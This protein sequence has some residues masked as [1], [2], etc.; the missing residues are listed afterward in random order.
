MCTADGR[1][2]N[3]CAK[4]WCA[5]NPG[6]SSA[7]F[8]LYWDSLDGNAKAVSPSYFLLRW[9][10]ALT[11]LLGVRGTSS[12]SGGYTLLYRD[13][14]ISLNFTENGQRHSQDELEA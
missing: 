10:H 2:R 3:L 12:S 5:S 4:V 1:C 7:H 8:T 9:Q 6:G 13:T 11:F 14:A